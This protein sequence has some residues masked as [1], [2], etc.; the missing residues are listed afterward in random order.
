MCVCEKES[1][2]EIE[3]ESESESERER[4]RELVCVCVCERERESRGEELHRH[5]YVLQYSCKHRLRRPQRI[6]LSS[7]ILRI[8]LDVGAISY[9]Y[10][11]RSGWTPS[12]EE[13]TR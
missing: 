12:A 3:R 10:R 6:V 9:L 13:S 7:S 11:V 8:W 5:R 1:V 2:C 4:E